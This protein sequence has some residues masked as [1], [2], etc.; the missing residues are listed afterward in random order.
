MEHEGSPPRL[1]S[2]N[3]EVSLSSFRLWK[4]NLDL[5]LPSVSEALV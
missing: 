1:S 5:A 3:T 4:E 2:D